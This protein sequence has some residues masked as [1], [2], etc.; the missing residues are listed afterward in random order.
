[1]QIEKTE[2]DKMGRYRVR[3]ATRARLRDCARRHPVTI[4]E[5]CRR[6][7]NHYRTEAEKAPG[8][9]MEHYRNKCTREESVV[10]TAADVGELPERLDNLINWYLDKK[11]NGK[12]SRVAKMEDAE[13]I[14]NGDGSFTYTGGIPPGL[15]ITED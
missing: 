2:A 10:I 12:V 6:A 4:A 11:D 8:V 14:D 9:N 1:M 5:I 7:A 13:C 15:D 3:I